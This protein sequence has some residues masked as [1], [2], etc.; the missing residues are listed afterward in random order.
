M[1]SILDEIKEIW[2]EHN[3]DDRRL[4]KREI[5]K[6]LRPYILRYADLDR[7]P[8]HTD[9]RRYIKCRCTICNAIAWGDVSLLRRAFKDYSPKF[10]TFKIVGC[11]CQEKGLEN[12]AEFVDT[13]GKIKVQPP[14]R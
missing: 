5:P 2:K 10:D 1:V 13:D 12:K 3:R 14:E 9:G 11:K 4:K 7:Q 6:K 8:V